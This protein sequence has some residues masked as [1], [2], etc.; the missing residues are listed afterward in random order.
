M[1]GAA[2]AVDWA[3]PNAPLPARS[4]RPLRVLDVIRT[5]DPSAG[6]TVEGLRQFCLATKAMGHQPE[7]ATLDA[8]DAP[9]LAP[10]PAPTHAL[11]PG[12]GTYGHSMHWVP[13]LKAHARHY[14]AIVLHGL[15]QYQ[16]YGTWLA[17]RGQ[18]V[19]YFVFTHGMLDPWFKREYPFKHLKKW[20]Y[21]P[22]AEYRVLRDASAVLFTAEDEARLARE[23]F[24]LYQA[25]EKVLGHGL[26]LDPAAQRVNADVYF[27]AFPALR[28]QRLLLFMGRLHEKKGCDLLIEAFAQIAALHPLLHL[29]MAG[30]DP[31]GL[32]ASL[33]SRAQALGLQSR[34]TWTGMLQGDLK[35]AALHAAD[36][37]VLPSHQENFGIAV[38]EALALGVPVLISKKINIWKEIV[39]DGAGLA[40][41]DTVAGTLALLQDWLALTPAAQLQ[42]KVQAAACFARRF[43]IDGVAGRLMHLIEGAVAVERRNRAS[44]IRVAHSQH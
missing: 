18:A 39:A 30:P 14:D 19:P 12:R 15:W 7:V 44:E 41:A 4:H 22:W 13:W 3:L 43:H 34:I 35:W 23:S 40:Q 2:T 36:A 32:Q 8:P 29:V 24:W 25:N 33:Q 26:A 21:W 28:G 38:V 6:G 27:Q 5:L 1:K 17:L 16:S 11:G 9:W 10:F 37:F 42:M 31:S 20:L